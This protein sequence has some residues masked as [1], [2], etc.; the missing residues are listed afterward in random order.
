LIQTNVP[1]R[2]QI[3]FRHPAIVVNR[4]VILNLS[5]VRSERVPAGSNCRVVLQRFGRRFGVPVDYLGASYWHAITACW[6]RRSLHPLVSRLKWR[7]LEV[8]LVARTISIIAIGNSYQ[9]ISPV[10]PRTIPNHGCVGG[11][12]GEPLQRAVTGQR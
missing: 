8:L 1:G 5:C 2:P 10:I 4:V 6:Q 7:G 3:T 11:V 12:G 9:R